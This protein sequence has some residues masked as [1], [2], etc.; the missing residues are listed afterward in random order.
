MDRVS[1]IAEI[2]VLVE[3]NRNRCLWFL[4][5]DYLPT[6]DDERLWVLTQIQR[7]CDRATFVRAGLC[8]RW[9][10]PTSSAASA[11]S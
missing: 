7:R 11:G 5:Q 3:A 4:R 9:L 1:L 6:T 8:K 2:D 10:S